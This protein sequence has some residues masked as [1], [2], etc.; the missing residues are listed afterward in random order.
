MKV[1][2][3]NYANYLEA[4]LSEGIAV[5]SAVLKRNGHKVRV[6][7]TSFMKPRG[8]S[9]DRGPEGGEDLAVSIKF[10]KSTPYG[11]NDLVAG[12]PEVDIAEEFAREINKFGPDLIAVSAMT[13]NYEG[14]LDLIKK[15]KPRCGVIFGGVHATLLAEDVI[16]EEGVDYVCVGEGEEA[17]IELCDALEKGEDATSI[18][19]LYVKSAAG[20]KKTVIRN[21]LREFT[22]LDLLP[23]P[24]LEEFDQRHFFRPFLGNV[25]KGIF[26]STSRGCPRGCYYC[27]NNRLRDMFR[28]CGSSYMRYQ[29]PE[30]VAR[31]VKY[32]ME[33]YGINW[34]KFSDDTFL[35][36]PLKELYRMRGL[37][38]GLGLM[39]GCSVDP[40]TVTEEKV[41]LAKEM[42]CVAMSIGVETGNERLRQQVLGR[43]ISDGQIR[44]AI[45]IV[46]D[47]GIKLSTFNIIGLPGETKEDIYQTLRFNKELGVPDSNAYILY[48]FPGTRVYQ[49]YNVSLKGR[50]GRIPPME[51]AHLFNMSKVPSSDLRFF[52]RAFNLYLVLPE[53]EW[54]RIDASADDPGLYMELVGTAQDIVDRKYMGATL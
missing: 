52:L 54:E 20:G 8:Y 45:S 48:P 40:A 19:N 46:R 12:D 39:F 26:M 41:G 53:D 3:V 32:L 13:T 27:V 1:L 31:N 47:H 29:S 43:R 15:V 28:P 2:F 38:K 5:L 44:K 6:F 36:R 11:L 23:P 10:Y 4:T 50:N 21:S 7:D 18:R 14:S 49:D 24:D 35:L 34:I 17:L 9:P 16:K 22:D 33:K 30:A 25:Y 37:L 51:E 42:G